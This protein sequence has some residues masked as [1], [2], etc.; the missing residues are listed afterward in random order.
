ML[1]LGCGTQMNHAWSNIDFSPYARLARHRLIAH[2]LQFC[3]LI[4]ARQYTDLLKLDRDIIVW[5]L[6]KG[7]PFADGT[8]DVVY[9]SHLLEH[10]E[11]NEAP[12]FLKECWRVLKVGGVLRVVVPDLES[13]V[14]RYHNAMQR[15]DDGNCE[16]GDDHRK[17]INELFDQ[18]VRREPGAQKTHPPLARFV[19]G[20]LRGNPARTGELHRWM[21]DRYSL[22]DLMQSVGFTEVREQSACSSY[23]AG[24]KQFDLDTKVGGAPHKPQSLYM[25]SRKNGT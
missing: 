9:H 23:V 16:A 20:I 11:R 17:A 5:N 2:L 24:W 14:V 3:G 22:A 8:F 13:M 6:K 21:Y 18:M 1:N 12:A 4:S 7:I 25:E 15:L 19:Q 10:L